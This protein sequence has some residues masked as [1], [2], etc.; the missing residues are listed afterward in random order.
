VKR[1]S[2]EEYR[3]VEAYIDAVLQRFAHRRDLT[4]AREDLMHPLTALINGN[5]GEFLPYMTRA[6][7]E[8]KDAMPVPMQHLLRI[9]GSGQLIVGESQGPVHFIAS[10][11]D[12]LCPEHMELSG[13]SEVLD[14]AY[15]CGRAELR[16]LNKAMRVDIIG[17]S[18]AT[19]GVFVRCSQL[20]RALAKRGCP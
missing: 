20:F 13:N 4:E 6:L 2:D 14:A 19:G 10:E 9:Q 15:Q 7:E 17:S 11:C 8:S 5:E 3:N 16:I 1:E 12:G 18:K